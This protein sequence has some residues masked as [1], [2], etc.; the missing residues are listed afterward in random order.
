MISRRLALLPL[1]AAASAR[2]GLSSGSEAGEAAIGTGLL[3]LA[4]GALAAVGWGA[5]A[6]RRR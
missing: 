5:A 6:R 4:A 2:W 1:G 3:G